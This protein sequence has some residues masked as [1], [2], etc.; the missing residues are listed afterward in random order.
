MSLKQTYWEEK[1]DVCVVEVWGVGKCDRTKFGESPDYGIV[2]P[3]GQ[4]PTVF[5]SL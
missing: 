2:E 4:L 5:N 1:K 3:A